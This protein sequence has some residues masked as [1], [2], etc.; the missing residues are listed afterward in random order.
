MKT[1]FT[2]FFVMAVLVGALVASGVRAQYNNTVV[3]KAPGSFIAGDATFPA[4]TYIIRQDQDD[5]GLWEISDD[6]KS[7]SAY[8]QTET[9][10]MASANQVTQVTFHKYGNT[11]ALKEIVLTGLNTRYLVHTSYSEKKAA[12]SGKPTKVSVPAEKK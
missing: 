8:V 4:G 7:H 10:D 6:S 12:K 11:L 5:L 1:L 2:R 3:F 9:V